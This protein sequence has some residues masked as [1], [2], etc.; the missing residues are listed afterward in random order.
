MPLIITHPAAPAH[1]DDA[2][3][4][5]RDRLASTTAEQADAALAFLSLVD[6]QAFELVLDA[7]AQMV[8]G[9]PADDDPED[10]EPA[11]V[12][13]HC[14]TQ[15]GIFLAHGPDWQHFHGDATTSGTQQLYD[16]GHPAE[17]TWHLPDDDL[18]EP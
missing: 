16:P 2:A 9:V 13:R 10:Q 4:K 7:A 14:G 17:A 8:S 11:P 6:P 1:P 18:E 3:R 15:V 5:R 12:C